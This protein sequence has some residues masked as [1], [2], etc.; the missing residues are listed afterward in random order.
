MIRVFIGYDPAEVVSFHVAAHSLMRHASQPVSITP[1][2]LSQ[3]PMTRPR[4]PMQSTEF[5]FSR[6]LVPYLCGFEGN[7]IFMDCDVLLRADIAELLKYVPD[8]DSPVAVVKHD[9]TPRDSRK[10][11]GR[12]QAAYS[13]KNWSSVMVFNNSLCRNALIPEY[14]NQASGLQLHRFEWC[15]SDMISPLPVEWNHLVGEY[16][17][18]PAAKLVHFTQGVPCFEG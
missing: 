8:L 13:C 14:V 7:A 2:M 9:Y 12:R 16:A 1:L 4:D 6:F 17:P 15:A 10:F 18:N 11:L 5:S 3:L